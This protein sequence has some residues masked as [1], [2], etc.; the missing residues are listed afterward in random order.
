MLN[1]F[2]NYKNCYFKIR[3]GEHYLINEF[4]NIKNIQFLKGFVPQQEILGN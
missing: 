1:V 3:I 4:N 2:K